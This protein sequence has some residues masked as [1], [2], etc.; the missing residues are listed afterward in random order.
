MPSFNEIV[1]SYVWPVTL[2]SCALSLTV[3]FTL[4]GLRF[5]R[6][7]IKDRKLTRQ[8]E[9]QQQLL[10]HLSNP[11]KDL[12]NTLLKTEKDMERVAEV[13]P[14]LLR[15]L[16]G[17]S[18]QRLLDSLKEI[19]LYEWALKKLH[20]RNRPR[21]IAA[22]NLIAHWLDKRVKQE[23]IDL[24]KDNHPLV[25][26]AAVEALAH[27][28]DTTLLPVIIR[29]FKRQKNIS[30]PL[31][32]DVFQRF[33]N[34]I[35]EQLAS[36]I[37]QKNIPLRIKIALLMALIQTDSI[38]QIISAAT[39]LCHH[40]NDEL[41]ALAY[42]ALFEAKE[43]V[44]ASLLKSGMC[45]SDWRVRQYTA[46]CA[47]HCSPLPAEILRTLLKDEN[48][49]VGLRSGQILLTNGTVGRKLLETLAKK[50]DLSAA[51]AKMILSEYRDSSWED[52][53][54]MA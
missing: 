1:S 37:K 26:Y 20:N 9:I 23:L 22:I 53:H 41:R 27:T 34:N 30:V 28:K 24:L 5:F 36:Y 38:E 35:S 50:D 7:R 15:T 19:G 47:S 44:D 39:A 16:K 6:D 25:Q 48:W 49:L 2:I 14:T 43:P 32:S 4:V 12:R 29:V 40:K 11:L 52:A 33:G 17:G 42:L 3:F 18:Y 21:K 13:V 8:K 45:D 10:V 31:M 46:S 54:G 51:R